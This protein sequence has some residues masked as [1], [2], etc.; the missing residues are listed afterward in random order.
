MM[1]LTDLITAHELDRLSV[2]YALAVD[3]R[4]YGELRS[5]LADVCRVDL[6]DVTN[7]KGNRDYGDADSFVQSVQGMEQRYVRTMHTLGQRDFTVEGDTAS[8]KVYCLVNHIRLIDGAL[9]NQSLGIRY[10]DTY[11]RVN[12]Q[13]VFTRRTMHVEWT[14][15]RPVVGYRGHD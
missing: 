14:D 6:A 15:E 9:V 7:G 13:W 5:L 2:R 10:S 1:D 12:G 3:D 11:A 4:R 8:G